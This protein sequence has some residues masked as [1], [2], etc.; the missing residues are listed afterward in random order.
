MKELVETIARALV[1]DPT[2]V[3]ATEE[4][5]EET[6]V[7][8]LTVAKEDMGRIIG[9]EGRTAKAI[10]TLLNAVSTKDNKKAILKIVE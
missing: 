10:R 6:N 7:I 5:E 8:K 1:D 3:K 2:Q 4:L 9:K